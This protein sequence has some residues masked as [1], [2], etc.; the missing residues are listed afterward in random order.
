MTVLPFLSH[1]WA[2]PGLQVARWDV[3][4][5]RFLTTEHKANLTLRADWVLAHA[6]LLPAP[7]RWVLLTEGTEAQS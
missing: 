3:R 5:Q 1:C 7:G 6:I 4:S 2:S